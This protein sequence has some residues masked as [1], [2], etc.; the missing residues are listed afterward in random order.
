MRSALMYSSRACLHLCAALRAAA[1]PPAP[2]FLAAEVSHPPS[3]RAMAL[4]TDAPGCQLYMGGFLDNEPGKG[5]AVYPQHGGFC[6][7]TQIFPDAVN[8]PGFPS[9][10]LKPGEEYVHTMVTQFTAR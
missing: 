7:E 2:L 8:Q 9:P 4:W 3:G 6:L 1:A 5:G 10:V